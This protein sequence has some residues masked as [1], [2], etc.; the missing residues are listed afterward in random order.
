MTDEEFAVLFRFLVEFRPPD[1][2]AARLIWR[3]IA[4]LLGEAN[5]KET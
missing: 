2:A 1:A 4:A 3:R 5:E